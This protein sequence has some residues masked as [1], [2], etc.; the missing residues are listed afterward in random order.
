M[1]IE[2][3]DNSPFRI[4]NQFDCYPDT[5]S[6][7]FPLTF[8][9]TLSDGKLSCQRGAHRWVAKCCEE[10]AALMDYHP[11]SW[12][13]LAR[14]VHSRQVPGDHNSCVTTFAGIVANDTGGPQ[15]QDLMAFGREFHYWIA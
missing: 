4:A 9:F 7:C 15:F 3:D 11:S 14:I 10:D 5:F 13:G 8:D 2:H 1:R 12:S 6:D